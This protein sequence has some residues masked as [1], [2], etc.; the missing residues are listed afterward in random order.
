MEENDN[1]TGAWKDLGTSW[2]IVCTH[3]T[4]NP[5][6]HWFD[7]VNSTSHVTEGYLCDTCA[8][9]G[10]R[11]LTPQILEPLS[12]E[13]ARKLREGMPGGIGDAP[14]DEEYTNQM[15]ALARYLNDFFNGDAP[16]DK[17]ETGFVLLVFKFD[18]FTGRANYISNGA[19]REDIIALFKE[20]IAAMEGRVPPD[21]GTA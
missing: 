17:R 13:S 2:V 18:P 20:Q 21:T 7:V 5:R 16:P 14:I 10:F 11:T 6:Q 8:R 3:L 12:I 9:A 19:R 1:G 15:R 4:E